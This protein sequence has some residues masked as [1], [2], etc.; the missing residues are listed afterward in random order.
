MLDIKTTAV[1]AHRTAT[2]HGFHDDNENVT[3]RIEHVW[4][5]LGNIHAEVSEAWEEARMPGFQPRKVWFAQ[6]AKPEGFG[7][8]LADIV[9]R[10]FDTAE[11]LGIDMED[12]LRMKMAYN[13]LRPFR[14]GDKR[15]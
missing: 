6:D 8:E 12:M 7:I 9:I 3:E 1:A 4:K 13:S 15:A 11:A 10:V 5:Y 2:Q 14:H